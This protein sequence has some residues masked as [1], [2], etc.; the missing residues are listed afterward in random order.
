MSEVKEVKIPAILGEHSKEYKE[1]RRQQMIYFYGATALT[2]ISAR[3]AYR[4]VQAR[5]C[6][7]RDDIIV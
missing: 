2:L 5:K 4:G 7:Y 1:R 3:L 6:K